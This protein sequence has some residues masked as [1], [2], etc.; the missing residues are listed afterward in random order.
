MFVI[1]R[2]LLLDYQSRLI[3][4]NISPRQRADFHKWLRYY[5]DFCVNHG[6]PADN[7]DSFTKF[8]QKLNEMQ[9]TEA[10]RQLARAAI[11][12]FYDSKDVLPKATPP[13][14]IQGDLVPTALTGQDWPSVY[15]VLEDCIKI[16]HYSKKT[17]QAYRHWTRLFQTF[18]KSKTPGDLDM[19]DVKAFLSF[20]AV[21]RIVAAT[22]QNQAFN[23][24][25]FLFK[26]VLNKEFKI[27]DGVVRAKHR[28]YVPV[29]V[30]S[31]NSCTGVAFAY[32]SA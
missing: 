3:Q 21:Q 28:P 6:V 20:L 11:T 32:S 15:K 22:T 31:R 1:P 18:T 8:D 5:F 30:F 16:R 25:L 10:N 13:A 14:Q 24:I 23:A 26:N 19:Q 9:Q 4:Q 2:P 7:P 12:I 29:V 17:W 27:T